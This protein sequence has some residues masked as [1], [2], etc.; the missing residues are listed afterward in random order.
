[1]CGIAGC[2]HGKTELGSS[3]IEGMTRALAHRGPDAERIQHLPFVSLGHRRLAIIDLSEQGNQPMADHT[4]RFWI[5][6][7]GEIYNY[8]EIRTE[9]ELKGHSFKT[10]SDTEVILESFKAWGK[11]CLSRFSGMF[12]FALWDKDRRELFLARDRFGKKP[13]YYS[14]SGKGEFCFA[15]EPGAILKHPGFDR[16]LNPEAI[17]QYLALGYILQPLSFYEGINKMPP[18]SWMVV[19]QTGKITGRGQFWDYLSFFYTKSRKSESELVEEL[20]FLM[21]KA[22]KKRLVSDVPV[23]AFLSGGIDSSYVTALMRKHYTGEVNTFSIG[24]A[25]EGYSELKDAG[26]M[27]AFLKTNHTERTMNAQM[28]KDYLSRVLDALDEP[29]SDNSSIP[30]YLVSQLAFEKMKVVLSG[31]GADELFAGYITYNADRYFRALQWIPPALRKLGYLLVKNSKT[32]SDRKINFRYKLRQFLGGSR[33]DACFAHYSW[34]MFFSPEERLEIMGPDFK[35]LVYDT[36]PVHEFRKHYDKTRGLHWLDRFLYVD[37]MTWLTDDILF[38][39]DR[40]TMANGLEARS[41][42]LDDEVAAFAASLPPELKM[43]GGDKK[44]LL[45]KAAAGLLPEAVFSKPKSGFNAPVGNWIGTGSG[46]E[47]RSFNKFVHEHFR[48]RY[49]AKTA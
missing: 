37:A 46:D 17:N 44:Y 33:G 49:P 23:G 15:S 19:D 26:L 18:A 1:M 25:E 11:E 9:L 10:R 6:F 42:F 8:A 43:K 38:K 2:I 13:L 5:V 36:D 7:N 27:A 39:A 30:M 41:P 47:F 45:K 12:A 32:H 16:K 24:F 14:H 20:R 22:V 34:R 21:E 31:D 48:G 35:D 4:G 40:M 28:G 3:Q 29:F